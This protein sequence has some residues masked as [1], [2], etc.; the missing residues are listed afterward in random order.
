MT[1]HAN[2]GTQHR[3]EHGDCCEEVLY[4]RFCWHYLHY[5]TLCSS[6]QTHHSE[7]ETQNSFKQPKESFGDIFE[8]LLRLY[9][10]PLPKTPL[11]KDD[12]QHLAGCVYRSF[13]LTEEG[14]HLISAEHL[15]IHDKNLHFLQVGLGELLQLLVFGNLQVTQKLFYQH[16]LLD[17]LARSRY[18]SGV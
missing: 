5:H 9:F 6:V 12:L 16:F 15:L 11:L 10:Y 14:N 3:E 2:Q 8:N 17:G 7:K 1:A 13:Y 18:F 4:Y